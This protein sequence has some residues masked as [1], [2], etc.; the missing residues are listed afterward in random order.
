MD[1]RPHRI[2][3]DRKLSQRSKSSFS[4]LRRIPHRGIQSQCFCIKF[5]CPHFFA[6]RSYKITFARLTDSISGC[7]FICIAILCSI[8]AKL[9]HM[10]C[11][12]SYRTNI[13]VG[14]FADTVSYHPGS[15]CPCHI[16]IEINI[17]K[18]SSFCRHRNSGC[19]RSR[20]NC[21]FYKKIF[22]H[23]IAY[24]SRNCRSLSCCTV[25]SDS[26]KQHLFYSSIFHC[27]CQNSAHR[28]RS[29]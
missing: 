17:F 14:I 25:H 9:L 19:R 4:C 29:V 6:Y 21:T 27:I 26:V 7:K 12:I 5:R 16:H 22:H 11:H 3:F 13:A 2:D 23:C 20:L 8:S 18:N 1:L 24:S 15:V 10:V 28:L